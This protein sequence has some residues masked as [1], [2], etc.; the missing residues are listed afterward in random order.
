M[1]TNKLNIEKIKISV[2]LSVYN[3]EEY[4]SDSIES[5]LNQSYE[6]LEIII[7]ND[8]STDKSLDI[9]KGYTLL[10]DRIILIN[11]KNKGLTKSLNIAIERA[12]GDY[13]ARQDADD[14]SLPDRF[15]N[16]IDFIRDKDHIGI[17][18][19]PAYIIN[20]TNET[21]KITPNFFRRNGFNKQI[22][23]YHNCMVHGTLII[24]SKTI[25]D[26]LYNEDFRFSQDFELYHRLMSFGYKISYDKNNITYKLR[27]HR[28]SISTK[29]N[30]KQ[31]ELF[32]S[33][34]ILNNK[35]YYEAY[36]LNRIYFR[37]LDV[38]FFIKEKLKY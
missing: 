1:Y 14:I 31:I 7:V 10:D 20:E 25:K 3:C 9:I 15:I 16:F 2:V 22:L 13:I 26:N 5:L 38:L 21:K 32:K 34:F 30:K 28:E 11:Q 24:K 19:T 18:S 12:T 37:I 4:L 35:K 33:I 23:D 17:Y 29:N 8:G 6:N 27:I 36:L